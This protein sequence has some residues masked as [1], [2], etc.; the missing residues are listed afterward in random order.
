MMKTLELNGQTYAANEQVF[1]ESLF[2]KNGTCSGFFKLTKR[3]RVQSIRLYDMQGKLFAAVI[4]N[5][6]GFCSL[7]EAGNS[8]GKEFFQHAANRNTEEKLGCP[9]GYRAGQEWAEKLL[10]ATC[11]EFNPLHG[12]L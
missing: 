7:V 3:K 9:E 4:R 2:N 5:T 8:T 12:A 11:G 1:M 10:N 6:S